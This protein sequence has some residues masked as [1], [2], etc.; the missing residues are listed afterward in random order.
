MQQTQQVGEGDVCE[1]VSRGEELGLS[2]DSQV[3]A[4][5]ASEYLSGRGNSTN[6]GLEV[7]ESMAKQKTAS[8]LVWWEH[9]NSRGWAWRG[10]CR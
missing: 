10:G 4:G 6:Y 7:G 5:Q 1:E 9:E 8:S 3:G 2:T